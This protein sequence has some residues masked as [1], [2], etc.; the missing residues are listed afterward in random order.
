MRMIVVRD[1][2]Q[3]QRARRGDPKLVDRA[4]TRDL[5]GEALHW[6]R[7]DL[8]MRQEKMARKRKGVLE[9]VRGREQLQRMLLELKAFPVRPY[10]ARKLAD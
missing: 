5:Q 10:A 8:E 7:Q 2:A 1:Q 9:E 6:P 3:L 4:P